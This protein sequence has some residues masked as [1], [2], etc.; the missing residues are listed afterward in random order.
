MNIN[1]SPKGVLITNLYLILILFCTNVLGMVSTYYFGYPSVYGLVRLFYFDAES[2]VPSL[3]SSLALFFSSV[4]LLFIALKRKE[5]KAPSTSWFGLSLIFLFLTFDE[6]ASIH[7]L[8][9]DPIRGTFELSGLLYYAWVVPYG[10]ALVVFVMAYSRFLLELP[11]NIAILFVLS[12]AIYVSGA[13]GVE[14]LGGKHAYL[15]GTNNILYSVLATIEE[16]LEMLGIAIFIYTL[17]TYI[18]SELGFIKITIT[19]VV[20]E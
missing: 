17:L 16:T 4:F 13:L 3:Y 5:L 20:V 12:G 2:N 1:L 10:V 8:L 19:K 7:E 15:Y 11:K 6:A 9:V 18:A 14:L